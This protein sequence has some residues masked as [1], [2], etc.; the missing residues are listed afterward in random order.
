MSYICAEENLSGGC[1]SGKGFMKSIL[2]YA[3]SNPEVSMT[4]LEEDFEQAGKCG[5]KVWIGKD[6]IFGINL[7]KNAF[8]IL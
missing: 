6:Y 2:Q 7:N 3:E 8:V 4:D 1:S 5:K